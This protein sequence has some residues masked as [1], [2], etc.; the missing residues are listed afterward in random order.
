MPE[1]MTPAQAHALFQAMVGWREVGAAEDQV[2]SV[3]LAPDLRAHLSA[4]FG[5]H[6]FPSDTDLCEILLRGR[7]ATD[8]DRHKL[9]AFAGY[10]ERAI[11]VLRAACERTT[12]R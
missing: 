10:L 2:V 3:P 1:P 6:G 5:T 9:L 8:A 7:V 12:S 11:G 4:I